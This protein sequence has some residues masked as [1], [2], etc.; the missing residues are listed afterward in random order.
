MKPFEIQSPAL[1]INGVLI[2]TSANSKLVVPGITKASTS[3][4]IEVED[5]GDQ[6]YDWGQSTDPATITIIDGYTYVVQ[7]N[8]LVGQQGW[9]AATYA[10]D[11]IDGDGYIDGISVVDGGAGYTGEAVTYSN[12][13]WASV[14]GT[15]W[16]QLPFKVRCGAGE[17]ESEFSGGGGASN[18]SDLGDVGLDG[19]SQGQVLMYNGDREVWENQNIPGGG[20]ANLGNL[21]VTDSTITSSENYIN[22]TTGSND[23]YYAVSDQDT[24]YAEM[25]AENDN[26]GDNQAWAWVNAS[27]QNGHEN[28]EVTVELQGSLDGV[29]KRWTFGVDGKFVLPSGGDIVDSTGTSVLGGGSGASGISTYAQYNSYT[30]EYT[31]DNEIFMP[32]DQTAYLSTDNQYIRFVDDPAITYY[33]I[34]DFQYDGNSNYTS[35]T[36][37]STPSTKNNVMFWTYWYVTGAIDILPGDNVSFGSLEPGVLVLNATGGTANTG[38]LGFSANVMFAGTVPQAATGFINLD[39]GENQ[40]AIGTNNDMPLLISVNE[41]NGA[42]NWTFDTSGNLRL[43]LGGDILDSTGN[44]VLGG[45]GTILPTAGVGVLTSDSE[46]NFSWVP[47]STGTHGGGTPPTLVTSATQQESNSTVTTVGFVATAL[48]VIVVASGVETSN[49]THSSIVSVD[50]MGLRWIRRAKYSDPTTGST[51]QSE[52]W[53]AVN[54]TSSD[55]TGDITITFDNQFDDQSTIVSNYLGCDLN[56]PWTSSGPSY[57]N[58]INGDGYPTVTMNANEVGT[59][60]FAFFATPTSQNDFGPGYVS[61]WTN[62]EL[63]VNNGA[64][65]WEYVTLSTQEFTSP[66]SNLTLV[67]DQVVDPMGNSDSIGMTLIADALV[68][69]GTGGGSA[70][71][72]DFV[73]NGTTLKTT[74]DYPIITNAD[75]ASA[76]A[77]GVEIDFNSDTVNHAMWFN[78]EDGLAISLNTHLPNYERSRW[79]FA[80]DGKTT[81]PGNIKTSTDGYAFDVA[82][83]NISLDGSDVFVDLQNDIFGG[84]TT[85]QVTISG[86]TGMTEANGIWGYEATNSNQF[87]LYTDASITTL[88]D[89]SAWGAYV[90]RGTAVSG[91]ANTL[92]IEVGNNTWEFGNDGNLT[93]PAGKSIKAHADNNGGYSVTIDQDGIYYV[94]AGQDTFSMNMG[95]GGGSI[96]TETG[97]S[98]FISTNG[99]QYGWELNT[100][101]GLVF[102]DNTV[103][104]T[105]YVNRN[106]NLDG[107][108]SSVHYDADIAFVDGGFSA[109]R[110]GVIDPTFDGGNTLTENNQ[111]N[112]DGGGA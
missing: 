80:P 39:N 54:T 91:V 45:G 97:K 36:L 6:S 1:S 104:T 32:G 75:N 24:N 47:A 50:G 26:D 43:P 27:L 20:P 103:Q 81:V 31:S 87:R 49:G 29:T 19:P 55:I 74:T 5:T 17:I 78:G 98:F 41:N 37:A 11:E 66:Q 44:T 63:V 71:I 102:P 56:N 7:D 25:Y 48:S 60:G 4:A 73:F 99:R 62:V 33:Q 14:D 83:A 40:A 76:T 16:I 65:F 3:V 112:L 100:R 108:G 53:Y 105:A 72:G 77:G 70:N 46:G 69:A 22:L 85:G 107:G 42:K 23:S 79:Y 8:Q 35:I 61:G 95:P 15:T 86:V 82:I 9:T 12:T 38:N 2:E 18:L 109:T 84:P 58:N 28:P 10:I 13:M 52:I 101:G 88:V 67:A 30:C 106:V 94:Y 111:L 93:L 51:Q 110:H 96:N 59:L 92:G 64:E 90:S 21:S 68:S 89:G 34:T 57:S